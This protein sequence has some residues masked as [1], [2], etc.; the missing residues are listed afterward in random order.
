MKSYILFCLAVCSLQTSFA[1]SKKARN[2][3]LTNEL[4]ERTESYDSLKY[5]FYVDLYEFED[6][7]KKTCR[8]L[9]T[10]LSLRKNQITRL[11]SDIK[12]YQ[13]KLMHLKVAYS[14]V[15]ALQLPE[16]KI[17]R[18]LEETLISFDPVYAEIAQKPIPDKKRK[19]QN[20]FMEKRIHAYDSIFRLNEQITRNLQVFREELKGFLPALSERQQLYDEYIAYL[21]KENRD[22]ITQLNKWYDE[23]LK[24]GLKSVPDEYSEVFPTGR[25]S[26]DSIVISEEAGG[27]YCITNEDADFPGGFQN[28][29]Y[30]VEKN[31]H[32]PQ[33]AF[34]RALEGK[35][36]VRFT[37]LEDGSISD[38]KVIKGIPDC[39]EC[40]REAI[41]LV[42]QM[43]RWRPAMTNGRAVKTVYRLPFQIRLN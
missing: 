32:I 22:L 35:A 40:D 27:C 3:F 20:E 43:P 7:I 34:E 29:K 24:K 11:E 4:R 15:K 12:E 42:K 37:I 13:S 10:T 23:N 18:Y 9:V 19:T 14:P 41:R 17:N 33:I 26:N 16:T 8:N 28:L 5:V 36:W 1:Q 25:I 31:Y 39:I 21:R 30:Y 38:V 2:V 6:G